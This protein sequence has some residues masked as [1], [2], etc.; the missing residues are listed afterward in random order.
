MN[1]NL[2]KDINSLNINKKNNKT[3]SIIKWGIGIYIA[4]VTITFGIVSALV[5][6]AFH[7]WILVAE[8]FNAIIV[9]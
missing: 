8:I 6:V 5:Y 4:Y 9:I 7:D 1:N 3:S 2:L